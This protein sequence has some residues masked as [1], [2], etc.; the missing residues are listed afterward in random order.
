M[1]LITQLGKLRH[2][3]AMICQKLRAVSVIQL[4]MPFSF[5]SLAY[6]PDF[7]AT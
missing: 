4:E 5:V 6:T 7:K 3:R 2:R 1:Y